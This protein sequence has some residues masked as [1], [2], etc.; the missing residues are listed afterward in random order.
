MTTYTINLGLRYSGT[1]FERTITIPD[2]AED[3]A[4]LSTVRAKVEAV[5]ASISGGQAD[6]L[7][8]FFRSDDFDAEHNIGSLRGIATCEVKAVDSTTII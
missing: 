4:A 6:D 7:A 1:D 8:N 5:N 2:V 3:D